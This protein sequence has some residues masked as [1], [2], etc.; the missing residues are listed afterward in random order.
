MAS[1]DRGSIVAIVGRGKNSKG[2]SNCGSSGV[3]EGTDVSS[4]TGLISV[5]WHT[6]D[7]DIGEGLI[8]TMVDVDLFGRISGFDY[9]LC[10]VSRDSRSLATRPHFGLGT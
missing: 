7:D 1:A 9:P 4:S 2:C 10:G 8:Y 5:E 3:I 6:D